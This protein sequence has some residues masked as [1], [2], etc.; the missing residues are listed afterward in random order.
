MRSL[1][2]VIITVLGTQQ[3]DNK[4]DNQCQKSVAA[5]R[6]VYATQGQHK[7]LSASWLV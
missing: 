7:C 3:E 2:S 4:G 5:L 1:G 6:D